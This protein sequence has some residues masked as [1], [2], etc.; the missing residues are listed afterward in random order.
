[1]DAPQTRLT[2]C[3]DVLGTCFTLEP[4]I[5]A[6]DELMGDELRRAGSGARM[7]I[8]DWVSRLATLLFFTLTIHIY[9]HLVF[10][11]SRP[12]AIVSDLC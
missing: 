11:P 5:E 8:M 2:V 12:R 4:V 3:M 1:M 9:R 6:L 10:F 7:V